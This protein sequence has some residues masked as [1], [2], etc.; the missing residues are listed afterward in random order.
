M[1]KNK[2]IQSK[3][4]KYIQ[5]EKNHDVTKNLIR[6]VFYEIRKTITKYLKIYYQSATFGEEDAN[7]YF[8]RDCCDESFINHTNGRQTWSLGSQIIYQKN[9]DANVLKIRMQT[10]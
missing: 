3:I 9:F 7:R 5:Q 10:F 1:K 2:N 8:C 4:H 6:R